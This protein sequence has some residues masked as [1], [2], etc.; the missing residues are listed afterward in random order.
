M[1]TSRDVNGSVNWA[2]IIDNFTTTYQT[3]INKKYTKISLKE[4][5]KIEK[6]YTFNNL[7]DTKS[8]GMYFCHTQNIIDFHIMHPINM[9]Y[10]QQKEYIIKNYIKCKS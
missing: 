4:F 5:E 3:K 9:T 1:A 10:V 2:H 6:E 8:F 7:T